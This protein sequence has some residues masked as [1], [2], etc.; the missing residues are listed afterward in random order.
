[1]DDFS[2]QVKPLAH[3]LIAPDGVDCKFALL[4]VIIIKY[5][6]IQCYMFQL[7]GAII[8]PLP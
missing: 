8:R 5:T 1:M 6:Y 3:L 2:L 7:I 4:T